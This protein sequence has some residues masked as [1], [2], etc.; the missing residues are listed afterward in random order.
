[1]E[2]VKITWIGQAGLLIETPENVIII[3]PY[4]S[5]SVEKIEPKTNAVCLWI[6]GFWSVSR[7]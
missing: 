6:N 1:M 4:L 7:R 3:D 2:K 5:D